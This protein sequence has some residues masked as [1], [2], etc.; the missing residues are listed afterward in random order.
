MANALVGASLTRAFTATT[1]AQEGKGFGLGDRYVDGSGNEY[2]YVQYGTGGA[3]A[4]FAVSIKATNVAVMT[5][6]SDSLRGERVGIAMATAAADSFGWAMIYGSA[7]V[8]TGE[9]VANAAMATTTTAGQLDDAA[10]AGTKQVLGLSLTA[11]RTG[12]AGLA[13]AILT[14]PVVGPTN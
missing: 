9:A 6:N 2:I 4:N 7:S 11:A 1:S 14:Y 13:N 3:T 12:G 5:T 10:G 8:Q